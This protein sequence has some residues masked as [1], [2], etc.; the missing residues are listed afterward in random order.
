MECAIDQ[1]LKLGALKFGDFVLKSGQKSSVYCDLRI[2]VSHPDVLSG[3]TDELWQIFI[4]GKLG[5]DRICGVP[6]TALPIATHL[7][8]K[9]SIPMII[10]RK[11]A[12][13]YGTKKMLEGDFA[14]G[15]RCLI[16]E[17]VVTTGSSVIETAQ[18][19]REHGLVVEKVIVFVDREQG[20]RQNL[21]EAG[22][23]LLSLISMT[24]IL[25]R[26]KTSKHLNAEE[27][28]KIEAL[29]QN[30]HATHVNG[31]ATHVNGDATHMNGDA[32]HVNGDATHMNGDATHVNRDA[33]HVNGDAT[34]V[35]GDATHV[36]RD[37]THVNGDAAHVN[38]DAT[39]VNGDATHADGNVPSCKVPKV[40]TPFAERI[41]LSKCQRSKTL[42]Q[43]IR[44][45][46]TT[47]CLSIDVTKCSEVLETLDQLGSHICL[48]KTHI[49]ILE[50]IIGYGVDKF[51]ETL[52]GLS[53]KYNFMIM[54]DRKF[55]DIG[56]TFAMQLFQ[57]PFKIAQW[58]DFVTAHA[59]CGSGMLETLKTKKPESCNCPA[60]VFVAEMS[61]SGNLIFS[62]YSQKTLQLGKKYPETVSGFVYRNYDV[63]S[64]DSFVRFM[65]GVSLETSTDGADQNY[66]TVE[67]AVGDE[68]CDVVIVGRAILKSDNRVATIESL[69]SRAW[70]C[71]TERYSFDWICS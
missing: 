30:G 21:K 15:E 22:I 17:D 60:V 37:A 65:P 45:K 66:V 69:K 50:D 62:E 47:V 56:N 54:E 16:V 42:L 3:I 59:V 39:H 38:G 58:A 7:S 40:V 2:L 11:E 34:H 23:E 5:I 52:K 19:L 61:S 32:T 9:H 48:V 1:L 31:D 55:S 6:Y 13:D 27:V 25:E 63:I 12:K 64:D 51:A 4:P 24:D 68:K 36:N 67:K 26:V 53:Q 43:I 20:A 18:L 41:E 49:D 57:G 29:A 71:Y 46:R 70:K 28:S 33:T 14:K 10:R 35:N 8:I 44:T